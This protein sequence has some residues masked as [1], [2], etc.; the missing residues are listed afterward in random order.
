MPIQVER[1]H[2]VAEKPKKKSKNAVMQMRD[3]REPGVPRKP[4]KRCKNV[5]M[6]TQVEGEQDVAWKPDKKCKNVK[7]PMQVEREQDVAWKPMKKCKNVEMPMQIDKGIAGFG[8]KFSGKRQHLTM[9]LHRN[10]QI[11]QWKLVKCQT[12]APNARPKS[13]QE[14]L[15]ACAALQAKSDY[16]HC[17]CHL[18]L[19]GIYWL[20]II[21]CLKPS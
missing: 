6:P 3:E 17:Q 1:G 18:H 14:K 10:I 16:P 9:T 21:H 20:G 7:I 19:C 5:E 2:D 11:P 8:F 12:F 13:G 4:E 15:Q